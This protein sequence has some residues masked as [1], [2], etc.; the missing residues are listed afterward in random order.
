MH[1]SGLT[2]RPPFEAN[3]LLLQ[4]TT[5][6]S[7]NACAFCTMYRDVRF[8]ASP[9]SEIEEDLREAA[10][11][12]PYVTRVFLENGDPFALPAGQL[13]EISEKIRIDGGMT[14][15]MIYHGD[16]GWRFTTGG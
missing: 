10:A 5:G 7:H 1:D 16:H 11:E 13:A 8:S 14:R 2:Y 9:M 15:Q 3:T 6:C 12:T 4:V